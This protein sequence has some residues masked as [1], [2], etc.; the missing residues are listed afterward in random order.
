MQY[1]CTD[2]TTADPFNLPIGVWAA[3]PAATVAP[4]SLSRTYDRFQHEQ[5]LVCENTPALTIPASP[6]FSGGTVT[7]ESHVGRG[8]S[9]VVSL[10]RFKATAEF[11]LWA[12]PEALRAVAYEEYRLRQ[13]AGENPAP[14]EYRQRLAWHEFLLRFLPARRRKPGPELGRRPLLQLRQSW[15]LW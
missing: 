4:T 5:Q 3:N 11:N 6:E 1:T 15:L 2:L 8:T 13:Q 10:P 9:V 7:V 12:D 14:E